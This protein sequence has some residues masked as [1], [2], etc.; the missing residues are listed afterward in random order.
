MGEKTDKEKLTKI[1]II[2]GVVFDR[3][4]RNEGEVVDVNDDNRA[5]AESLIRSGKA[6]V[7]EVKKAS[8]STDK[9]VVGLD[10]K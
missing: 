4:A 9:A 6:V 1:T 5:G 3:E 7:G 2:R 8:A 10:K